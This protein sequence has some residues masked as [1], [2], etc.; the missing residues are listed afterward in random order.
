MTLIVTGSITIDSVDTSTDSVRDILGGS[1]VFFSAAASFFGPVRLVGAVG[2]DCP[3]E[4]LAELKRF[5]VDMRGLE[6][7]TGSKTFRW[8]GR[9]HENMNKRDTIAIELNVLAEALPPVPA[10]FKDSKYVFLAVTNPGNQLA[11]LEQFPYHKLVV[12]DTIDLYI[13]TE[14]EEL[15]QVIRRVDG[16]VIND[17]E[18][19]MLTNESNMIRAADKLLDS[20]PSFVVI[21]K[22]EHGV[23]LRHSDGFVALPA[24]PSDR[25]VD[26]TGAG[27]SFAGGMMGFMAAQDDLSLPTMRRALAYG[28]SVASFT[29]EDFS[30]NRLH[31]LTR[32]HVDQRYRQFA[33][34]LDLS[35]S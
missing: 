16:L 22:G 13:D 4:Y 32:E 1:S 28:T 25:V 18:A 17:T 7:R 24:Y 35:I 14:R 21:K 15:E 31:S 34:M 3:D 8:H 10:A 5:G 11:L 9:Y 30:L 6:R 2:G 20:G 29:I 12:A 26:P 27:D 23:L 19:R 33:E